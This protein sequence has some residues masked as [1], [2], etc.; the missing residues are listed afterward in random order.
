M[1]LKRIACLSCALLLLALTACVA[2]DPEPPATPTPEPTPSAE[3]LPTPEPTP[4]PTPEPAFYHPLTG[5]PCEEDL[6]H[7]RPVAVMLNN[8]RTA[9]PQQ[10]NSQADIIYELVAEGGITT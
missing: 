2:G 9:L 1:K 8:L 3:P 7:K 6:S 5:L 4:T 10:G